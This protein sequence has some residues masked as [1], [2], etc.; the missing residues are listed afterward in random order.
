MTNLHHSQ[1]PYSSAQRG[2]SQ[3]SQPREIIKRGILISFNP[4]TYT[5]NILILEA[6]S[7]FLQG[8]PVACH[9][10]G[11]SAQVN[12]LCAVLFFDE[13]N[14]TD[15]VV[16]AVYPNGSQGVPVPTPGRLVFVSGYQQFLNQS[17]NAGSVSTFTLTGGTSGIPLGALGVLYKAFF[18]SATVGAYIQLAPHAASDI[19]AYASIGNLAIAN[20]FVNGTGLLQLDASGRVD[21]KANTG[22]CTVTLYTYGYVF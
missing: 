9:L 11:T 17:I 1:Q 16:L 14:Y 20:G 4:A 19:T 13:Q 5:A 18:T 6:T 22:T 12:S 7:A 3:Q 15:A 10:D 2:Q 8:I 21:V